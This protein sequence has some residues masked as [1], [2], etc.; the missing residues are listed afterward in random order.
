MMLDLLVY[1]PFLIIVVL[2]NVAERHRLRPFRPADPGLQR[3]L[4]LVLRYL[5]AA[6]LALL[7]LALLAIAGLAALAG[8]AIQAAPEVTPPGGLQPNWLALAA[9]VALTALAAFAPLLPGLRRW[10]AR[11]LPI[12][13]DSV[14]HLTALAFAIYQVGLSLAQMALIGDL[15]NLTTTDLGLTVWSVLLSGLPLLLFALLGIGLWVRRD[16]RGVLERLGLQRLTWRHLLLAAG[17]VVVLLAFDYAVTLFWQGVDPM[18]YDVL[19]RVTQNLFGGLIS[20][21]GALVLGLSAGISE[22]LLFRGAVQPRL[23][24]VLTSVLFAV[25]HL[26]YSLSLATLEILIIG[27]VLGLIRNRTST[28][29]AILVHAGYNTL[30][31]LLEML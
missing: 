5:P 11:W 31:V 13:P 8:V 10:L 6:Q 28:T 3:T 21:G 19:D 20:V 12:D 16:G 18:G 26:Q 23:G 17:A 25:G 22:E 14:V 27:L 4:D 29:V 9:G 2:A 24:L 1:L 7:N 30:G 15:E